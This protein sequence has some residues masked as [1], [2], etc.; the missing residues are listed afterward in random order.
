MHANETATLPAVNKDTIL[1]QDRKIG[2]RGPSA[3]LTVS[4]SLLRSTSRGG[5]HW[6]AGTANRE[7]K[8]RG[9][10]FQKI[11]RSKVASDPEPFRLRVIVRLRKLRSPFQECE[12]RVIII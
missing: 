3:F 11:I 2:G 10:F 1:G 9:K 4:S 5:L 6:R 8:G 7:A 12:M